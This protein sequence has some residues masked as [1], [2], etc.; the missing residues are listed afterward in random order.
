[1]NTP[2]AEVSLSHRERLVIIVGL[3]TGLL[4]A[5]LDQTIVSTALPTIV[6]EFGGID[7]LSWVVTAYLL[8]STASMPLYGKVS[9]LY[10]RKRVYQVAIVVFIAAS[11]LCGVAQSM[12]QL[13]AFRAVQGIG[14]GGLMSLTFT[15]VGDLVPPRERGRYTGYLTGTFALASVIGPLAGGF[16]TDH[17]SWR[18]VFYVN[19]PI[20][21]AAVLITGRVL[22]LPFV[23]VAR[24][25]DLV[26]AAILVVSVSALLLATVWA[27]EEHGWG[28]FVTVAL[29]TVA[30]VAAIAFVAWERTA[31]EPVLPLRMFARP[32]F[33]SSIAVAAVAGAAM[34]GT[35]V[36]LP[37]FFQGVQGRQATNAGLLL[38]PLMTA[39]MVASLVVGRLTTRT[40]RYKR[41]PVIGCSIAAAGLL[42]MSTMQPATS[43]LMSAVWMVI[44]GVGIGATLSVL[45]VA[46]QNAVELRDLGA[47][48][49]TVNFF[50]TLG[51]TVGVAVF[52]AILTRRLSGGLTERLAT[53]EVPPGVTTATL[54]ENPRAISLLN[55]P[56]R[57]AATGALTDAITTVFVVAAGVIVVGAVIAAAMR[58]LPLRDLSDLTPPIASEPA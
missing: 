35:I 37:L 20:G 45:T 39:M 51:A 6:G 4:L 1:M 25:L 41:Y 9:D 14:A 52:G 47:G 24:R 27:S 5:A 7:Q 13:V 56:L 34:F 43:R 42:A 21:V 11:A 16:L 54:T 33:S 22:R 38:M 29:Y 40:G 48:T 46:V 30:V 36:Y 12:G 23:R 2:A 55:E 26:G 19:L 10:G 3:M 50:R 28:S 57:S 58:E 44:L 53:V 15:I 8:A 32:G 31:A 18:W 17:L 49:A